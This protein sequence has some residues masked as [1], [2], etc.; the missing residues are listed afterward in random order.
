MCLVSKRVLL[1]SNFVLLRYPFFLIL[2]LFDYCCNSCSICP[3]LP[4]FM[5]F[6]I[7]FFLLNSLIDLIF[8]CDCMCSHF[9][10]GGPPFRGVWQVLCR[11]MSKFRC[12]RPPDSFVICVLVTATALQ[13][14]C[15]SIAT[16]REILVSEA[17]FIVND[18]RI[19]SFHE[20]DLDTNMYI[21]K[22]SKTTKM[23][24]EVTVASNPLNP[25][26]L[27]GGENLHFMVGENIG[28][29]DF[30][31]LSLEIDAVQ[32][33][34]MMTM[35]GA[36]IYEQPFKLLAGAA[37][38]FNHLAMKVNPN[39]FEPFHLEHLFQPLIIVHKPK[40]PSDACSLHPGAN[41]KGDQVI[42]L[43]GDQ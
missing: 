32:Q 41:D 1:R 2:L 21:Q 26:N 10:T 29:D 11:S 35:I 28:T 38:V 7:I 36:A 6:F 22:K 14:F 43:K 15:S 16:L 30:P 39:I 34:G 42:L 20:E 5:F 3:I 4:T 37:D 31:K 40:L 9:H 17:D 12:A 25:L 33:V 19:A 8:F 18:L 27:D 13:H 24:A 23:H